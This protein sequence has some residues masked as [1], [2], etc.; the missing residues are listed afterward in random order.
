LGFFIIIAS[1]GAYF[2]FNG[3]GT[4]RESWT[5]SLTEKNTPTKEDMVEFNEN[6]LKEIE[7]MKKDQSFF[8]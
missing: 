4:V 8:S 1:Y 5:A 3:E 6:Q 2:R 7:E